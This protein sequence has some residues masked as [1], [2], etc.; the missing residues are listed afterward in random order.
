VPRIAPNAVSA[1]IAIEQGLK[2]PNF[3]IS[4][5]CASGSHAIGEAVRKV[6][7][8][9][10]DV[11][12]TGGVE[13]PLSPATF[14]AYCALRVLSTRNDAPEQA[15]RPF[16][17]DRDGFVMAEGTAVLIVEELE[18]AVRR[19]ARIYAELV[20]Y[21]LTSGAYHMVMP[22]P[23]GDD[24]AAAMRAAL[25][26]A[27]ASPEQVDYINAHGTS[28][29]ANDVAESRAI[30][31]VFGDRAVA[32]SSTKSVTGHTI[33]AAGAIEAAVCCLTLE[34]Q[35]MPPTINYETPDPECELDCVPNVARAASVDLA[36]SN[37]FGFGSVN[38]CLAFRRFADEGRQS[39]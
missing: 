3:V 22:D 25:A 37:S 33:G 31:S 2:G 35:T 36:L 23:S 14:A 39:Q 16:D 7:H 15:S 24:A 10:A 18:H 11:V 6:Q 30:R 34:R 21:G 5:A 28:T 27:H 1:H 29:Q 12:F 8:G 38:A 20:G 32:V 4:T 9:E 19:E 13:A 26:D 17:K